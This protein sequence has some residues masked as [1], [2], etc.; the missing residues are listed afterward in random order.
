MGSANCSRLGTPW[1]KRG[2]IF[3]L[4]SSVWRNI[5]L[6]ILS[7]VLR[8]DNLR[9]WAKAGAGALRIECVELSR[10]SM[11]IEWRSGFGG[12]VED[13]DSKARDAGQAANCPPVRL[14]IRVWWNLG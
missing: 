9:G 8:R 3:V 6:T 4:S 7:A 2:N 11:G 1:R 12:W 5:T 14:V 13:I 10:C